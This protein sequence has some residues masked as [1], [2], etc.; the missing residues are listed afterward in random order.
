MIQ[1]FPNEGTMIFKPWG[2]TE[3]VT[4]A[5]PDDGGGWDRKHGRLASGDFALSD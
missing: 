2:K 1:V 4:P 5:K 3:N